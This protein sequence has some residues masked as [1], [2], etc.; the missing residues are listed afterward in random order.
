MYVVIVTPLNFPIIENYFPAELQMEP[1][2]NTRI[3]RIYTGA[4]NFQVAVV[5][6]QE[7]FFA[8][9]TILR[10]KVLI[11]GVKDHSRTTAADG[12][13]APRLV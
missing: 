6:H 11:D 13:R 12:T 7:V 8:T 3:E 1:I 10:G 9:A 4:R 5:M 2:I